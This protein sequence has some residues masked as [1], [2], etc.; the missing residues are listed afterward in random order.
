[1]TRWICAAPAMKAGCVGHSY[2]EMPV[3]KFPLERK[4]MTVVV[5]NISIQARAVA[6]DL[7]SNLSYIGV[8]LIGKQRLRTHVLGREDKG[9]W[10]LPTQA[11]I[12]LFGWVYFF[13]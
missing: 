6:G 1:M 9:L 10:Y 3:E 11:C 13:N 5:W 4:V 2:I 8:M 12:W 7:I